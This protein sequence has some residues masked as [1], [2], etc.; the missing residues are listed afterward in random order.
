VL[1]HFTPH[2]LSVFPL[3]CSAL[4]QDS[5]HFAEL[6]SDPFVNLVTELNNPLF[7]RLTI[8]PEDPKH[9]LP[10]P[11]TPFVSL[12]S[13]SFSLSF[14]SCLPPFLF[15]EKVSF[16]AALL[17]VVQLLVWH[18]FVL[19]LEA[20]YPPLPEA[21]LLSEW[22]KLQEFHPH[23]FFFSFFFLF[24]FLCRYQEF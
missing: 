23:T 17:R 2:F 11:F 15:A 8:P 19:R 24:L 21:D 20:T 5:A 18:L 16:C 13:C 6:M 1:S 12:S 4:L 7:L 10:P 22:L 9:G 14:S 3:L